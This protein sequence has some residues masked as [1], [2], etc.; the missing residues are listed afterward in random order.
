MLTTMHTGCLVHSGKI[1]HRTN[2]PKLKPDSAID[3]NKNM[4]LVDKAD[5]QLNCTE[6]IRKTIKWYKK[7][8]SPT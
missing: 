7:F 4:S 3:Y 2:Q 8:F 1:D 6:T 5:M